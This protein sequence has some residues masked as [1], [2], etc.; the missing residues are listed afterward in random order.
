[1]NFAFASSHALATPIA[2]SLKELEGF[3]GFISNPDMPY[4]RSKELR[5][6]TFVQSINSFKDSI[7]K[8]EIGRAH[9]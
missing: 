7:F 8:P 6:N 3:S 2:L 9:V 4:G 5:P 1:M